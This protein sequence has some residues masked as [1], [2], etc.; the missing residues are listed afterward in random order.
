MS[1]PGLVV[2]AFVVVT[3]TLVP[4]G[5]VSCSPDSGDPCNRDAFGCDDGLGTFQL[6]PTCE[7]TGELTIEPGYGE[8]GFTALHEGDLVPAEFGSQGGQHLFAALRVLGAD[9]TRYDKLSVAIDVQWGPTGET[10]GYRDIVL[11]RDGPIP[12]AADGAVEVSGLIVFLSNWPRTSPKRIVYTVQD[13]CG[14]TGTV[15]HEI[16]PG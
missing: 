10:I 4:L 1:C 5:A 13:P 9:L 15:T 2:R 7:L 11:G 16:P 8:Y 14:R 6:D 3:S 12:T